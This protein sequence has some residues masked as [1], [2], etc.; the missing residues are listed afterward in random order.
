MAVLHKIVRAKVA[1]NSR[2]RSEPKILRDFSFFYKSM[3]S[4]TPSTVLS[5]GLLFVIV[6]LIP[7]AI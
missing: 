1:L 6:N 5:A 2:N 4:P 3:A 7:F